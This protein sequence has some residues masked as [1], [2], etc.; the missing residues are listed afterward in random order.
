MTPLA[1]P[2]LELETR[3]RSVTIETLLTTSEESFYRTNLEN[4]S[5]AIT[6]ED[7]PGPHPVAVNAIEREFTTSEEITRLVVVGDSDFISLVDQVNGNLDF[8]MNSFGWLEEQ[9]ET[10]SIRPKTTLQFPMQMTGMQQLI[11]GGLFVVVIPL[12]ILIAGLVTWLRRRH[13]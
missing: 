6:V 3:P 7:A 11:F 13:L 8:L 4:T 1:R 10:L 12:G 9:D 5:P 2:V